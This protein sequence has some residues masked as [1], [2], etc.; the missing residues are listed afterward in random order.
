MS[1]LTLL[2]L[3][4]TGSKLSNRIEGERHTLI[5]VPGKANRIVVPNF[6]GFYTEHLRVFDGS[7]GVL[8]RGT[9]YEITYLY[10]ELSE[11][12]GRSICGIIVI[13]NPAVSNQVSINYRAVGGH[14]GL[15]VEEL[16][17]VMSRLET[18]KLE[19]TWDQ[20]ANPPSGYIVEPH[21]HKWW[22]VYG[23]DDTTTI[24]AMVKDSILSGNEDAYKHDLDYAT[25]YRQVAEQRL[26]EFSMEIQTHLNR[27]DDPH[28]VTKEQVGLGQLEDHPL[29][30]PVEAQA[31]SS[32]SH[33]VTPSTSM[34]SLRV[35]ALPELD[36]HTQ[37]LDN[38]HGT[39]AAQL[40]AYTKDEVDAKTATKLK[41]ADIARSTKL[42]TGQDYTQYY[43]QVRSSLPASAF[44]GMLDP[45]R[46]GS[47]PSADRVLLGNRT[48]TDAENLFKAEVPVRNRVVYLHA[49]TTAANALIT[50]RQTYSDITQYPIGSI[51]LYTISDS[52]FYDEAHGNGGY[53][54]YRTSRLQ[55]LIRNSDDW[56]HL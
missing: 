15:S 33:Y 17:D 36:T 5:A 12:T 28:Q 20:I 31:G 48:W 46:M 25:A 45:A 56:Q 52:W 42:L 51:V 27:R 14:F 1:E 22:Q 32:N 39:T 9:D 18:D 2:P 40:G 34:D 13:T 7:N 50:A 8:R 21:Q 23:M 47:N 38:P 37:N 53:R 10:G 11:L 49:T 24:L 35:N 29:A 3:D 41:V 44:V 4:L 55:A 16:K 19:L 43:N 54:V 6:G 30:T 26:H